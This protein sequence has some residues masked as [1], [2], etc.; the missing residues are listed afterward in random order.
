VQANENAP[1]ALADLVDALRKPCFVL[2]LGRKSCPL[3][4]PLNPRV[5]SEKNAYDALM[6]YGHEEAIRTNQE[7]ISSVERLVWGKG[8][9]VGCGVDLE[10]IR[11]DRLLSRAS[12][13][14][15]DRTEYV[16]LLGDS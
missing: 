2:Y 4:A 13:Q 16:K 5:L 14:F 7:K 3:S 9:E 12:W 11:K 15:G 6:R 8:I 10:T 1:Y